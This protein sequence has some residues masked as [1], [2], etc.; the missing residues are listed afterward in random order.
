MQEET[1][2][3]PTHDFGNQQILGLTHH[4][5]NAAQGGTDSTMHQQ[6]SQERPEIFQ[7]F[8]VQLDY[9][10]I[11]AGVVILVLVAFAGGHL[12]VNRVKPDRHADNNRSNRQSIE[13][14]RKQCCCATKQ[15]R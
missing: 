12:V 5:G 4:G 13:E 3:V 1:G 10:V 6:A 15:Q 8:T 11:A 14:G 9:F 2:K 7:I